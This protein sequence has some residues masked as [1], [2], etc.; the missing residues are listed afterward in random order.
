MKEEA[1]RKQLQTMLNSF[2]PGSVLMLIGQVFG[3]RAE[4]A[5]EAGSEVIA[6]NLK[7]AEAAM[8]VVG[9]GLDAILPKPPM[10]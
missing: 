10:R 7:E 1:A 2:S 3:E 6:G 5:R 8:N 4:A 9:L